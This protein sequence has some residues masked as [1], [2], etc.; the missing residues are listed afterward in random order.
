M[1]RQAEEAKK[2]KELEKESRRKLEEEERTK[3]LQVDTAETDKEASNS[4]NVR[5]SLVIVEDP[6]TPSSALYY[7]MN[8]RNQ[9]HE[10]DN[11]SYAVE[12]TAKKCRSVD[13]NELI[14]VQQ[15]P[16][17]SSD[18]VS[19]V[20]NLASKAKNFFNKQEGSKVEDCCI[21]RAEPYANE[22]EPEGKP[23]TDKIMKTEVLQVR[24][25][26]QSKS[27]LEDF[28]SIQ[29]E[30]ASATHFHK[31]THDSKKS[32]DEDTIQSI[33][34]DASLGDISDHSKS[35]NHSFN[36]SNI[37]APADHS[38]SIKIR[39]R[40]ASSRSIKVLNESSR[41]NTE[42]SRS[43]E[44]T[45]KADVVYSSWDLPI[46]KE[47][48][49]RS[50]ITNDIKR[51][52]E[53]SSDIDAMVIGS[54]SDKVDAIPDIYSE[55][56]N[57]PINSTDTSLQLPDVPPE[58]DERS[59]NKS[60][61]DSKVIEILP[62]VSAETS[63][64]AETSLKP[65]L[66]SSEV[67]EKSSK[68]SSPAYKTSEVPSNPSNTTATITEKPF[69]TAVK[70]PYVHESLE[71]IT[72]EKKTVKT[73][74]DWSEYFSHKFKSW[75]ELSLQWSAEPKKARATGSALPLTSD[76][77]EVYSPKKDNDVIKGEKNLTIS[78]FPRE[79]LTVQ[80]CSCVDICITPSESIHEIRCLHC[81]EL[82][83]SLVNGSF[84]LLTIVHCQVNKMPKI[85]STLLFFNAPQNLISRL[86][87]PLCK[88]LTELNLSQNNLVSTRG[89]QYMP[90][91]IK[92]NLSKNNLSTTPE[93]E[94]CGLLQDLDLSD[95]QLVAIP[96]LVNQILLV[97]LNLSGNGLTD[98]T[99][100]D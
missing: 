51:A 46:F 3:I 14:K 54:K 23:K 59:R 89:L 16:T 70:S 66:A 47:N 39:E 43:Y 6:L 24:E 15:Q 11:N 92:L 100:K 99:G 30:D 28:N 22:R 35:E 84:S 61:A 69:V 73:E 26:S 68:P 36:T 75:N 78:V 4:E 8:D 25:K 72:V 44:R 80:N 45:K 96:K 79:S 20:T 9:N 64:I 94:K 13:D 60:I 98:P 53:L 71:E 55:L 31:S 42:V 2:V 88:N 93:L 10:L 52:R 83:F 97:H 34:E 57:A 63:Q 86:E 65:P 27:V 76:G 82:R 90:N 67:T 17:K 49:A 74:I 38:A 56:I 62:A 85:P 37:A 81:S 7:N 95:N 18:K 32:N 5:R 91:L 19:F 40:S 58:I 1:K 87:T 12:N 41:S 50:R 77:Y 29:L 33:H 21:D 48:R